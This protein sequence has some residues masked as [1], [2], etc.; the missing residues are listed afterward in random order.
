MDRIVN[1]SRRADSRSRTVYVNVG[2]NPLNAQNIWRAAHD[3]R[4]DVLV[5][6]SVTHRPFSRGKMKEF[7]VKSSGRRKSLKSSLPNDS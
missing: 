2:G 6:S 3:G 4:H 7:G 5:L 1:F